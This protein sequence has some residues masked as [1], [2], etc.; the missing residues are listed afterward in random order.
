MPLMWKKPSSRWSQTFI[1]NKYKR[2]RINCSSSS[3]STGPNNKVSGLIPPLASPQ[4]T[5]GYTDRGTLRAKGVMATQH[6]RVMVHA[7]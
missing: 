1:R 3:S 4:I 5:L 7:A 6:N 2:A